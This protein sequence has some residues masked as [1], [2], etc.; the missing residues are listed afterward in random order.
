M[1]PTKTEVLEQ[2]ELICQ[3]VPFS[4]SERLQ[5]LLRHVVGKAV[6]GE[7]AAL[8]EVPLGVDFFK[9]KTDWDPRRNATVRTTM[10]KLRENL[11][12]YRKSHHTRVEIVIETGSY[13]P[14]FSYSGKVVDGTL[15]DRR[16]GG[17]RRGGA[18]R[19]VRDRRRSTVGILERVRGVARS[20]IRRLPNLR[21]IA[22]DQVG[23]F[24]P[25]QID[26]KP[27]KD[28]DNNPETIE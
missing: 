6:A 5:A 25:K 16:A 17:D 20:L 27:R 3:S 1:G 22:A 15:A 7:T 11:A 26:E 13:I 4:E 19:R 10:K 2:V 23:T 9:Q 28:S 18:D 24:G 21:T 8:R 12:A 14:R